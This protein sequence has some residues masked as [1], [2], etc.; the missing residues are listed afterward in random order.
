MKK[1]SYKEEQNAYAHLG[2]KTRKKGEPVEWQREIWEFKRFVTLDRLQAEKLNQ[3]F[4]SMG[5]RY[6]LCTSPVVKC[7]EWRLINDIWNKQGKKNLH[8]EIIEWHNQ[9]DIIK[10][11]G[12]KYETE[13]PE[14]RKKKKGELTNDEQSHFDN[15]D[16]IRE[17]NT[18]VKKKRSKKEVIQKETIN[19]PS[20]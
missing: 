13:K 5:N 3:P 2:F 1:L 6:V 19:K 14:E 7:I 8:F 11:T 18:V 16:L 20:V 17:Q 12:F 4:A 9:P 15:V 10:A